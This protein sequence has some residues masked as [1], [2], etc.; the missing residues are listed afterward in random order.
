MGEWPGAFGSATDTELEQALI[1]LGR[2]VAYPP[3]PDVASRVRTTLEREPAHPPSPYPGARC[4]LPL[5]ITT[6]RI[7]WFGFLAVC[8][9]VAIVAG[10]ALSPNM[11]TAIAD[12]LG[13][14]GVRISWLEDAP[15][16]PTPVG[17]AL[18]LGRPVTLAEAQAAAEF[19][20]LLPT[21]EA[22]ASP[23]EI[24]VSGEGADAMISFIY[25]AAPGLP[26]ASETGAGALLTQ[27]GGRTERSL[28][29]KGLRGPSESGVPETLLEPVTVR[30]VPGFWISGTP[31]AVFFVCSG[32]GECRQEPYRLAGDVLLWEY[33]GVTLRLESGLSRD[34]ALAIAESVRPIE[35]T[36]TGT[37]SL[38][39]RYIG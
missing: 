12:R 26:A 29:E 38:A 36:D 3:T 35:L 32:P 7:S 27:F 10:V 11:R 30:G 28:I 20:L 18:I 4:G 5:P 21:A 16:P 39:A 8:L 22:F 34:K 1:A 15:P 37:S 19:P 31:H 13:L 24:Y 2:H 9:L 25:P 14:R 6:A 23:R 17:E 33:E